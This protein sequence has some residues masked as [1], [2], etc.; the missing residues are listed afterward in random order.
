M[1][2]ARFRAILGTCGVFVLVS[3]IVALGFAT[4]L[5]GW[6][7]LRGIGGGVIASAV[8]LRL[9][10]V[11]VRQDWPKWLAGVLGEDDAV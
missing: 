4:Q 10:R 2:A 7:L 11:A 8:G 5:S 1:T 3:G 6:D 9:L